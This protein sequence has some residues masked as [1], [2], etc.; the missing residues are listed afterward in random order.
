MG[1]PS[2]KLIKIES[3]LRGIAKRVEDY[4]IGHG[5]D[6]PNPDCEIL[7]NIFEDILEQADQIRMIAQP[8][9]VN[10]MK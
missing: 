8:I 6:V 4:R 3:T 5:I 9:I 7:D 10:R 1:I 2:T